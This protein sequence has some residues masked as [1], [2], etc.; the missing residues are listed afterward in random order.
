M[1]L[2]IHP[3]NPSARH[4]KMVVDCLSSGGIII[5]PTDTLYAIGCDIYKPRSFEK[6]ALI[7]GIKKEKANFSFLFYDLSQLADFTRPISNDVYKLMKRSLPG[8]YTFILNGNNNI[9]KI[10]QTKKKTIGIRI[11]Q[12]NIISE[13]IRELGNPIMSTSI[14]KDADILEYSTDPSILYDKYQNLVDMVIDGG[15]ADDTPS[16]IIDCTGEEVLVVRE[17]KGYEEL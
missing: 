6:V 5:Y 10:F 8:P 17:G 13:V 12:N 16:T 3:D 4:I 2:K 11:P 9:P 15:I 14:P 7:K 1:L